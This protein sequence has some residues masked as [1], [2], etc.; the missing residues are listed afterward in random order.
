MLFYKIFLDPMANFVVNVKQVVQFEIASL[1]LH[2]LD[3]H[4]PGRLVKQGLGFA[5]A[6]FNDIYR[7]PGGLIA[8][9]NDEGV[10]GLSVFFEF[11]FQ[12]KIPQ[13]FIF[14]FREKAHFTT[15]LSLFLIQSNCSTD[16]E[17]TQK[18]LYERRFAYWVRQNFVWTAF[19]IEQMFGIIFPGD[20]MT[21]LYR[22]QIKVQTR[23]GLPV[24][25]YWRRVWYR[26]TA[27]TVKEELPSR[28]E[29]W[30]MPGPPR[31]R[32]ETKQGLVC[33]LIKDGNG[34]KLERVW[35]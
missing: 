10:A 3:H 28:R 26:V 19:K 6:L 33:D 21:K 25:F 32:C 30:R 34:W 27:C 22:Q 15:C 35:D 4:L 18:K 11:I 5:Q 1:F 29:W 2:G 14:N 24:A 16:N 13:Y 20:N 17:N 31:Y 8:N 12:A 9:I 23:D 7:Q